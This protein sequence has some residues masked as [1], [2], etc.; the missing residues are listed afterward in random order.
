MSDSI[1]EVEGLEKVYWDKDLLGA[2]APL[3]V[4]LSLSFSRE[5]GKLTLRSIPDSPVVVMVRDR[6][7]QPRLA[8]YS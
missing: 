4:R 6:V 7:A 5:F 8:V 1:E 3:N 2:G